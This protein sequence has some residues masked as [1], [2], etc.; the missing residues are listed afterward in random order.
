MRPGVKNFLAAYDRPPAPGE[1]VQEPLDGDAA[2]YARRCAPDGRAGPGRE[3][4]IVPVFVKQ[5]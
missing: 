2:H 3:D 5:A 1:F 4:R